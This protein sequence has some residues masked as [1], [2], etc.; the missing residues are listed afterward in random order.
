MNDKQIREMMR[1]IDPQFQQ[2]A[3]ERAAAVRPAARR[4][5]PAPVWIGSL[6]AGCAAVAAA[7]YLPKLHT[8]R[9]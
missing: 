2:K 3:D 1:D 6:A 7:V 8:D 5:I 9:A 4:R